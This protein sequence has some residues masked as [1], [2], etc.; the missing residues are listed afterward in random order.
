MREGKAAVTA[1]KERL[2]IG[3]AII[4]ILAV[5]GLI[6]GIADSVHLFILGLNAM[7]PIALAAVGEVLTERG[8]LFNIGVEGIMILASFGA[9]YAAELSGSGLWDC[10]PGYQWVR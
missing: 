8:G 3:L 9:V 10:W 6:V 4:A 5:A 7:V 1:G 2:V